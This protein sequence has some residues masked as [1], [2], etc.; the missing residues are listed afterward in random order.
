MI[1]DGTGWVPLA[2]VSAVGVA[3]VVLA[4]VWRTQGD[5][6]DPAPAEVPESVTVTWDQQAPPGP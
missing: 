4:I 2:A 5:P 1:G 6:V 3:G